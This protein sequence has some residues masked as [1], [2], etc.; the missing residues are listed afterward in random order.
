MIVADDKLFSELTAKAVES[1]RKRSHFNFHKSVEDDIHRLVM[2]AEPETYVRPHCHSQDDRWELFFI[3][4][5]SASVLIFDADGTVKD[6]FDMEPGGKVCAIEIDRKMLHAFVSNSPGTIVM[7]V[8]RGPYVPIPEEDSAS[9]APKEGEPG[10]A[11][12]L[13]W[14]KGAAAGDKAAGVN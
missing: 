1:P 10:M 12:F 5:G 6:R 11:E 13:A 2:A 3:L 8:K 9:W 4:Q 7:E 14:M